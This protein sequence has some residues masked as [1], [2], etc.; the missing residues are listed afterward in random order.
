MI[1]SQCQYDAML[2]MWKDRGYRLKEEPDP[3]IDWRT[4]VRLHFKGEP[5]RVRYY[6]R[7]LMSNLSNVHIV[8]GECRKHWNFM[9]K[10]IATEN[11]NGS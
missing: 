9:I 5:L 8:Q 1:D 6:K 2:G 4:I 10:N 11:G 7:E 3:V